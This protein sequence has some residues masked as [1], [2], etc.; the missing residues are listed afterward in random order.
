LAVAVAC[1]R[2]FL[3]VARAHN[4]GLKEAQYFTRF[5][6]SSEATWLSYHAPAGRA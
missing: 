2:E 4:V 5:R 1:K 6:L 3:G